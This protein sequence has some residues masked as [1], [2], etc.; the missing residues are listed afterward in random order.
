[1]RKL[2]YLIFGCIIIIL[3]LLLVLPLHQPPP[4][5][6]FRLNTIPSWTASLPPSR[7]QTPHTYDVIIIGGGFGGLSCGALL[8]KDGYHVL[9]LE[10]NE[11]VGGYGSNDVQQ[12]YTFSYGAE[13]ISGV[14]EHGCITYLVS[15]LNINEQTMLARNS[16]SY[17]LNGETVEIPAEDDG[18]EKVL[19]TRFSDQTQA[20]HSFFS[21]A[22]TVYLQAF[23]TQMTST[24]GIPLRSEL[25]AKA[26]PKAWIAEYPKQ[27][28]LM[29]EWKSKTYREVLDE[30]FEDEGI[31]NLLSSM[32][33]YI[34]AKASQISASN[35]IVASGYF[36]FGGYHIIGGS[37]HLAEALAQ[38]ISEN[39][40]TVLCQYPVTSILVKDNTVQGVHVGDEIFKAPVVVS[41][42]NAKTLYLD[43]LSGADLPWQFVNDIERLPMGRS[44]FLVFLGVSELFPTLPSII[45]DIDHRLH[46]ILNSH[47][48]RSLAPL[49]STSLTLEKNARISDFPSLHSLDYDIQIAAMKDT[50][51]E[52]A[53]ISL[54]G[55][56][57]HI[58]YQKV[59]TPRELRELTAVPQGAAYCFDQSD[60]PVRPYFKSPIAGLYVA[61][62]SSSGGGVEAVV[63]GGI[64]CKHDITGWK[65]T[66]S[67]TSPQ[68]QP[69]KTTLDHR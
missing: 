2:L 43:L 37:Q 69:H 39:H 33:G 49:G 41:N 54:P 67:Y 12:G 55:L 53:A 7:P 24:W 68:K 32:L 15:A 56:N 46:I 31:K 5:S 6:T 65:K 13:D 51:I 26:M 66:P 4:S 38:Y 19:S 48:D 50:M 35:V 64:T 62:A 1:M 34:G 60:V 42:V 36:F 59:I 45:N 61:N 52:T 23:D 57:D 14:W 20:I 8:A 21:A 30:Y 58:S 47:P 40:G 3:T 17:L 29:I 25:M 11:Q 16:R 10:K 27:H 28:Q 63:I 9:V 44:S 22:K 18:F